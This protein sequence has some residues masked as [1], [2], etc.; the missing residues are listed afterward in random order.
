MNN[1]LLKTKLN[2]LLQ[3]DLNFG[4]F[5]SCYLP[6]CQVSGA[7]IAKQAGIIC[8][9]AIPQAAYDLLGQAT[10]TPLVQDGTW[11][12]AGTKLGTVNGELTTILS[13][14]RVI[15]NLLQRL[16]AIAT[17]TNQAVKLLNNPKIQITDTRKTTPGLRF[18]E[19]YAVTC[20]GGCNHRYDLSGGIM[21]KDNHLAACQQNLAQAV[22]LIRQ[23]HGP[24]TAIEIEIETKQQLLEA[25]KLPINTVMFDNQTPET[26][27]E[28]AKLVPAHIQIEAS[29]GINLQNLADFSRCRIDYLSLGCL[30]NSI[31]NLDISFL[32]DN[33]IKN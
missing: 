22:A 24:L 4:D 2:K 20:G 14:E 28:W 19:K 23:H 5:S 31:T 33:A 16:S 27:N 26:I 1:L 21:L 25:I 17:K 8:G 6:S 15:L 18:F 12:A 29:G 32:L 7:F 10:Y 30:T 9:Q 13:G 11:V 3:E